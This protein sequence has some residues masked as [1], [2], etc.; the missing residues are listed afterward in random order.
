MDKFRFRVMANLECNHDELKI[1]LNAL[2][3]FDFPVK[4]KKVV[5]S[6]LERIDT[7]LEQ[8]LLQPKEWR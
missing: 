4:D 7:S 2:L 3:L 1:L 6:L 5:D 8:I